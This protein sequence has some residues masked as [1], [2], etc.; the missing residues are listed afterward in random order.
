MAFWYKNSSCHS[1]FGYP[2]PQNCRNWPEC[3]YH[4]QHDISHVPY[5]L[6]QHHWCQ[7]SWKVT[8]PSIYIT[9]DNIK[10]QGHMLHVKVKV[11]LGIKYLQTAYIS[12]HGV[13]FY[14]IHVQKISLWDKVCFGVIQVDMSDI[15]SQYKCH[16][17]NTSTCAP[18][19]QVPVEV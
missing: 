3:R 15:R 13:D 1:L 18:Y 17:S 12:H 10:C 4:T 5:D 6:F 2:L 8:L 9:L 11:L 16:F 7:G 14:T 19:R